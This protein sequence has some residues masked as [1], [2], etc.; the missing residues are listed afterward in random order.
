[1]RLLRAALA[2]IIFELELLL[3]IEQE[4]L[5][6]VRVLLLLMLLAVGIFLVHQI[7][8]LLEL[9]VSPI[10]LDHDAV[11][12]ALVIAAVSVAERRLVGPDD[13]QIV[14]VARGRVRRPHRPVLSAIV[15]IVDSWPRNSVDERCSIFKIN[16]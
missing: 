12:I 14:L 9:A 5:N 10:L 11:R 8:V 6:I 15:C 2:L 1:M 4:L 7:W 3:G 13:V 16:N